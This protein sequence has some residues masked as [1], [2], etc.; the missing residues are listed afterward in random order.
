MQVGLESDGR[1]ATPALKLKN[2][3]RDGLGGGG[4]RGS[5]MG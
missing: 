4:L 5:F 1:K 2:L 3:T